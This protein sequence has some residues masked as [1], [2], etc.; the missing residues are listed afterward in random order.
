MSRRLPIH[1]PPRLHLRALD[2]LWLQVTGTR[3]NIACR[4]CFITCGPNED[5]LPMMS[6]KEVTEAIADGA[7]FGVREYYFTGGEPFLHPEIFALIAVALEHGPLSI[8][9]N[10]LLFPEET[11]ARLGQVFQDAAL[12]F[13][14]RV[15][16][17][18]MSARENDPVRG[19]GTFDEIVGAL[20]RLQA[21]GLNPAVTVVEHEEGLGGAQAREQ[22]LRFVR[23]LGFS[24]PRVKFLPLLRIGREAHRTHGY[25]EEE[26]VTELTPEDEESLQCGSARMVT[27]HGV[28][29]CPILVRDPSARLG[30]TL[31]EGLGPIALAAPACF[32]CQ[33]QGLQCRT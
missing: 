21:H 8:L 9:T 20:R 30:A 31:R 25:G 12:S 13:D 18:G 27:A 15:S 28:W 19:R 17:D 7:A 32:T 5:A 23:E 22:F 3:C 1:A 10:G 24:R 16:L 14:L 4:H 2:T 11:C 26:R 33:T 29:P 6:V